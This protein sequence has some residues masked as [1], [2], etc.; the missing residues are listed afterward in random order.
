MSMRLLNLVVRTHE[1]KGAAYQVM[2]ALAWNSSARGQCSISISDIAGDAHLTK[3][4]VIRALQVLTSAHSPADHRSILTKS[5]RGIGIGIPNTYLIDLELLRDLNRRR[6]YP[7][8]TTDQGRKAR[9]IPTPGRGS[10]NN[11][12]ARNA[13]TLVE[14]RETLTLRGQINQKGVEDSD[15]SGSVGGIPLSKREVTRRMRAHAKQSARDIIAM[16][17]GDKAIPWIIEQSSEALSEDGVPTRADELVS[18][19]EVG[20]VTHEGRRIGAQLVDDSGKQPLFPR[21]HGL[22]STGGRQTL[23]I[24]SNLT[25]VRWPR[26]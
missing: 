12:E 26:R 6:R 13:A 16:M 21:K 5:K 14:C 19:G 4:S 11:G 7:P 18:S 3:K 17:N 2:L 25:S 8:A 1:L 10:T 20:E 24:A 15:F 22:S 23:S 9:G